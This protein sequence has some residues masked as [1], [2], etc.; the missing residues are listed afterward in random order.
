MRAEVAGPLAVE[1]ESDGAAY[2]A[3]MQTEVAASARLATTG[4]FGR[5]KARAEHHAATEQ[6]GAARASVRATWDEPPRT[7]ESL[8]AWAGQAAARRAENDPRVAEA[9]HAVETVHARHKATQRRH[10]QERLALL[11]SELGADEARRDQF[12]MRT[13]NPHRN[14]HD[15]RESSSGSC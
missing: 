7:P 12:G 4:R 2:L 8:Y 14:A 3:T 11:V 1:A 5:R 10:K 15:A 6:A 9:H 13:V